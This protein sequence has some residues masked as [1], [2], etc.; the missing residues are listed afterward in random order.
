MTECDLPIHRIEVWYACLNRI[1]EFWDSFLAEPIEQFPNFTFISWLHTIHVLLVLAKLSFLPAD[2]WDLD[3]VR[4]KWP[5][6]T[7][8]DRIIEKLQSVASVESGPPPHPIAA[9]FNLYAEKMRMCK[10]WYEAKLKAE[11][12]VKASE[13]AAALPEGLIPNPGTPEIEFQGLF[14]GLE[15]GMWQEFIYDWAGPMQF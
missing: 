13:A 4:T 15:D 12:A 10:R 8:I 14:D 5:F 1:G 6:T 2:G 11:E 9:R 7:F 3:F